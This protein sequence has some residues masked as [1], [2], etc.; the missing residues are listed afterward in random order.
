MTIVN[1]ASNSSV[2]R[3]TPTSESESTLPADRNSLIEAAK[4][5]EAPLLERLLDGG[6]SV[7]S[8]DDYGKTLL[9]IAAEAGQTEAVKI[10]LKFG[11]KIDAVSSSC[12]FTAFMYAAQEGHGAILEILIKAGADVNLTCPNGLS[13]LSYL[14][15]RFPHR[16]ANRKL[17]EDSISAV[18][19]VEAQK[20]VNFARQCIQ[21]K[22][23]AHS[24]AVDGVINIQEVNIPTL[25]LHS[26]IIA[27]KIADSLKKFSEEFPCFIEKEAIKN[28]A[29]SFYIVSDCSYD[30]ADQHLRR[31]T[32][33]EPVVILS[34]Y[35][36]HAVN[37]L[38]WDDLLVVCNRGAESSSHPIKIGRYDPAKIN[39][40][41]IQQILDLK[42]QGSWEYSQAMNME[43]ESPLLDD[44]GFH[45]G[46]N[47]EKLVS[48]AALPW[49]ITNNC[50]WA[51]MEG[52][53]K[54]YFLLAKLKDKS[55]KVPEA[56]DDHNLLGNFIDDIF[57]SWLFFTKITFIEKYTSDGF[58][59]IKII[60][61]IFDD[62]RSDLSKV[63]PSV[64][65][66]FEERINILAKNVL[67]M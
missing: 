21:G 39:E 23:I 43:G 41:F 14:K 33:G 65:N 59:P 37:F 11:A 63:F 40:E 38:L 31:I 67:N 25:G 53:V 47:E 7:D 2:T 29:H 52:I 64:N 62:L 22:L 42:C 17:I 28:I 18:N 56:I 8:I 44:I 32:E 5:G 51:N 66:V 27:K 12:H 55:F 60:A 49:Q 24:F 46:L 57:N 30:T 9:M 54:A 48:M 35:G 3:W 13:A 19:P 26:E 1:S 20:T 50:A 45:T 61:N 58:D 34:G 16:K 10:L 15:A 6:A 4:N 36:G